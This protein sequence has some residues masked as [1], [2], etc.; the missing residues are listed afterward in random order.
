MTAKE[1]D[2]S[3]ELGYDVFINEPISQNET[4]LLPNGVFNR[5]LP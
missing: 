4:E 1:T 3:T 5:A 2:M